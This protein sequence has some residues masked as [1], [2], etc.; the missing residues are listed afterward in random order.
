[1]SPR[2]HLAVL[3]VTPQGMLLASSG[4]EPGIRQTCDSAQD[5]PTEKV[6][7]TLGAGLRLRRPELEPPEVAG[8][9]GDVCPQPRRAGPLGLQA[10]RLL[11]C[12]SVRL[13]YSPYGVLTS[14][15]SRWFLFSGPSVKDPEATPVERIPAHLRRFFQMASLFPPIKPWATETSCSANRP[16]LPGGVASGRAACSWLSGRGAGGGG[17]SPPGRT[18]PWGSWVHVTCMW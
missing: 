3:V 5:S 14:H 12:T 15:H 13:V 8:W 18:S 4:Q 11:S 17:G 6:H 1:M 7:L 2:G 16:C 9:A 10:S